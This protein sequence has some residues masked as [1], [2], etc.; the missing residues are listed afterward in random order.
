VN[1]I[2][3]NLAGQEAQSAWLKLKDKNQPGQVYGEP[4]LDDRCVGKVDF[5]LGHHHRGRFQ[6]PVR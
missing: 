3:F 4:A 2:E 1:C 5:S 6:S